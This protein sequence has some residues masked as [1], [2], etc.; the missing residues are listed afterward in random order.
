MES[1]DRK[2]RRKMETEAA[3]WRWTTELEDGKG[4]TM[5]KLRDRARRWRSKMEMEAAGWRRKIE[6]EDISCKMDDG[7]GDGDARW[8]WKLQDGDQSWK[9]GRWNDRME[10]GV[11]K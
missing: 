7:D 10:D 2:W 4:L 3:G 9:V 8:R 1:E 5:W 6:A 11:G